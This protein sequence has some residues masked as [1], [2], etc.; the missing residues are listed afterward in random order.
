MSLRNHCR[1]TLHFLFLKLP[2]KYVFQM[3][4]KFDAMVIFLA[5]QKLCGRIL[6]RAVFGCMWKIHTCVPTDANK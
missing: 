1:L 5:V 2:I 4:S 3:Q 6:G